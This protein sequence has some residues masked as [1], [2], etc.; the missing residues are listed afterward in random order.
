LVGDTCDWSELGIGRQRDGEFHWCCRGDAI[1]L[2]LCQSDQTGKM[3]LDRKKLAESNGQYRFVKVPPS[4]HQRLSSPDPRLDITGPTG[5]YVLAISNCNEY[6]R[7]LDVTGKYIWMSEHGYLPGDFFGEMY[8]FISLTVLYAIL[9]VW[10]GVTMK[11]HENSRIPIQNYI[12]STIGIGFAEVFF[13][14]GDY[15]VW[16]EDGKRFWFALY[17]G[18]FMGVFKSSVSRCLIV[19]VCLGWGVVRDELNN[20]LRK[21]YFLGGLYFFISGASEIIKIFSVLENEVLGQNVEEKL[22]D[23]VTILTFSV[24]AIDVYFYLW[25]LESLTGTMQYLEEMNQT[26]KLNRYLKLRMVFLISIVFAVA[27]AVFGIVNNFLNA[28]MLKETYEWGVQA[29]WGV[30]YF[31]ILTCVSILWK[32]DPNAKEFAYVM[33]LPSMADNDL[34]FDTNAGLE[35]DEEDIIKGNLDGDEKDMEMTTIPSKSLKIDDAVDA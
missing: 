33:E 25:I 15:W 4:G 7:D 26:R 13:R 30:N 29:A 20:Y 32:P 12:L 17:T 8:F 11:I 34:E 16:N 24:A 19:M 6:A 23:F 18:I 28:R 9:F 10:Y 14:A 35:E 1:D 2:Q 27:W 22:F 21:I 31:V 3:I 5:K